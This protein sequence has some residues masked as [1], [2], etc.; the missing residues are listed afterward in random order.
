MAYLTKLDWPSISAQGSCMLILNNFISF[1]DIEY[2]K[3]YDI[4]NMVQSLLQDKSVLTE[5][6]NILS[7]LTAHM[8]KKQCKPVW[9]QQNKIKLRIHYLYTDRGNK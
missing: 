6:K 1:L 5:K 8:L 3:K 4:S 7:S 9:R 2:I